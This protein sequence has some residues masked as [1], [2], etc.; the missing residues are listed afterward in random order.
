[1][2][3]VYGVLGIACTLVQF[4]TLELGI[5][6][7]GLQPVT[8]SVLGFIGAAAV[9][10]FANRNWTFRSDRPHREALPRFIAIALA[11]LALNAAM[12]TFLIHRVGLHH[13]LAQALTTGTVLFWNF[14]ANMFWSF[15]R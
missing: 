10:Y 5:W 6:W 4:A 11:A 15:R 13:L 9:G 7:M 12:M 14:G 1:M 3:A 8:A 2:L